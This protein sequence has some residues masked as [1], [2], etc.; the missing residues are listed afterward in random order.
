MNRKRP[1]QGEECL[2]GRNTVYSYKQHPL[3]STVYSM[4]INTSCTHKLRI[5]NKNTSKLK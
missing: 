2:L 1:S 3:I 5:S 4:R